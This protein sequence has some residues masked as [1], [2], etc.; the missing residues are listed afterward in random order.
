MWFK[1]FVL[2]RLPV[3]ILLLLAFGA[4]WFLGV[5]GAVVAL[6]DTVIALGY[7]CVV[8]AN[9]WLLRPGALRQTGLLLAI[10]WAG[11]VIWIGYRDISTGPNW[12]LMV[13]WACV[14]AVVWVLPN[15]AILYKAR[16]LFTE[17]A[18]EKPG[19]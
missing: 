16:A 17:P 10:E 1:A 2:L 8:T 15:V 3:S 7:L 18:K 11:A 4:L 13:D 9:L 5:V 14:V 12:M 6:L 19:L